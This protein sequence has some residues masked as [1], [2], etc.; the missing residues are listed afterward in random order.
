[1]LPRKKKIQN[2]NKKSRKTP[3]NNWKE[4]NNETL[5]WEEEN[6]RGNKCMRRSVYLQQAINNTKKDSSKINLIDKGQD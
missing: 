6:E 3:P 2:K 4:S 5:P 1:M